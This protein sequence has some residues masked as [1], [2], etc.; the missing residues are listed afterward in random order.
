MQFLCA[1]ASCPGAKSAVLAITPGY[2]DAYITASLAAE[3]PMVLSNLYQPDNFSSGYNELLQMA[4]STDIS[5]TS[6]QTIA[7][8]KNTRGQATFWLWFHLRIGRVTASKFKPR[9]H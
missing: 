2:C 6:V 9:S 8:D 3:L 4:V 5:V 1:L 7:A